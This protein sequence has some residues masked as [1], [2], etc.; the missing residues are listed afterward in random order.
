MKISILTKQT[1]IM[2]NKEISELLHIPEDVLDRFEHLMKTAT[3][4]EKIAMV[5]VNPAT[6][7]PVIY[8][9]GYSFTYEILEVLH[10]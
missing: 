9:E 7:M 1:I 4:E 6:F 8:F 3:E 10:K 5:K 2:T